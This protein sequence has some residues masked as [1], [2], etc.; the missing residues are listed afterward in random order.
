MKKYRL[1]TLPDIFVSR[2]GFELVCVL[3]INLSI[4]GDW[5]LGTRGQGGQGDKGEEL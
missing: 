4:L 2:P 1:K 5:G 3:N